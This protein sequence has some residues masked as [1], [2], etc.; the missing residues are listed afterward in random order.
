M[1]VCA[2]M[3][4]V[5]RFNIPVSKL[6]YWCNPCYSHEIGTLIFIFVPVA[7]TKIQGV[8]NERPC[9]R[10]SGK[11]R[12]TI[13]FLYCLNKGCFMDVNR[14]NAY[15]LSPH[16]CFHLRH[17]T[18]KSFVFGIARLAFVLRQETQQKYKKCGGKIGAKECHL[19]FPG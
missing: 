12:Q 11:L 13:P 6:F 16:L 2:C 10:Q 8:V 5:S 3:T 1:A 7:N 17:S 14:Q 4:G 9:S 19:F 18:L 15:R